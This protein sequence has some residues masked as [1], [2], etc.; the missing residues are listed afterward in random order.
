MNSDDK[1]LY[2][3]PSQPIEK[4]VD[5]LLSRMIIEEKVAQLGSQYPK[6][7]L[8]TSRLSLEKMEK[9]FKHGIGQISRIGGL[10]NLTSEESAKIANGIQKFLKEKTRL[11]IPA[12]VH[13]ECLSGFTSREGTVFPQIIGV[14][15]TWDP[16]LVEAMTRVISKQMRNVGAHQALS[17]VLD[18]SRD[19]R[20]GRTEETFG[21]DPY[22][23]SR[24]GV[25][26]IK[27][28]QGESLKTGIIATGKHFLGYGLPQGGRNWG[29]AFIPKRELLEVYAKPFEAAIVESN[30]GSIMNAYNE[31]DGIPCG[32]S[33]ELLTDLLRDKLDFTGMVV[34]DYVT[35]EL[36]CLL[37]RIAKDPTE[38]GILAIKAG[39]DVELPRTAGYGRGFLKAVKNGGINE[40]LVN[41]SV[42]RI[43]TK[44]F[45]LGLFENP[46][47]DDNP[48]AI[49][50]L[51][52]DPE[53]KALAKKIALKSMVL[54]KNEKNL[55][56]LK[57]NIN[58]L[59]IIGPNA[60]SIRNLFGDYAFVSQFEGS[61]AD[62]TTL[63]DLDEETAS[64]YRELLESVDKDAFTRSIYDIN[65]ILEAIKQKV[66][67]NTQIYYAKGCEILDYNKDGF[68]EA[69]EIAR[70]AD[71]VI[72]V[73]GG[74]SGMIKDCTSGEYRD[75]SRLTLPSVQADLVREIYATGTPIVLILIN[76]RPLSI[77]WEKERIPAILEAWLPG[78]QGAEAVADVLFGDYNPGGKLPISIP[79]NVGQIPIFHSNKPTGNLS[80]ATWNYVEENTEPLFP[81]GYGLSY[82]QFEYSDLRINR[83][84]VDINDDIEISLK[85]KNIGKY[86]GD[87]VIQLYFHDR[88]ATITR[89]IEELVGF[90][91][92]TLEPEEIATI[93]F[94]VSM[95]QLG[96]YNENMEY[97]VEPGNVDVYVGSIHSNHSSKQLDLTNDIISHRD[98]KLKAKFRIVGET[99]KIDKDKVFFSKVFIQK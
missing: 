58:S 59:A 90:K 16:E 70:K 41:R 66:S 65:S 35:L 96:F 54:L 68:T 62:V 33:H 47:V 80:V 14:A 34:S 2:L 17:P 18:I 19:P 85:V 99:I 29:P 38:A 69:I 72:L 81:F 87:E 23:V 76:G 39:L 78:E 3:D 22:L 36:N 56:P 20:W 32:V 7:V 46:Y 31:I 94:I 61:F 40:E 49:V 25:A 45:E 98:V 6:A 91:R 79:R 15:S 88:E 21:E 9:C 11:G 83:P 75:R 53:A 1:K 82:T 73:M 74:K 37:H 97:V 5:D 13:E 8:K 27:G 28:L 50:K 42:T 4:R 71:I 12:I 63:G 51:F 93:K 92:I 44:K 60:N 52:L 95:K 30:I 43:L 64:I 84:Q 26:Y 10:M 67:N 55:L 57:K 77:A 24:M 89:P 48:E 86:R